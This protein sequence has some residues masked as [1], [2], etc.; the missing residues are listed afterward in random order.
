MKITGLQSCL[1]ALK[2][3]DSRIETILETAGS[4]ILADTKSGIGQVDSTVASSYNMFVTKNEN[5]WTVNV[6]SDIDLSAYYEFG[7]GG[8]VVVPPETTDAY[9]MQWFKTG[10]G[11]LRP[12]ASLMP[13][14]RI[15]KPKLI[16]DLT[17]ELNR[18]F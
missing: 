4:K 3:D 18:Q 15:A 9:T 17:N 11:T 1:N 8:F 5:G 7:T 6:G 10:K 12:H 14:F 2:F 13:A 16:Q